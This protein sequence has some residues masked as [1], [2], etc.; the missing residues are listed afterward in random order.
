MPL[1]LPKLQAIRYP[2]VE[3]GDV[4][5]G[6]RLI[7]PTRGKGVTAG[8]WM[9]EVGK[10]PDDS[11]RSHLVNSYVGL[12]DNCELRFPLDVSGGVPVLSIMVLLHSLLF[13][14]RDP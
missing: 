1:Q 7:I 4:V 5:Y 6:F 14:A 3:G 11:L 2:T 12:C 13:Q 10:I 9:A 8:G